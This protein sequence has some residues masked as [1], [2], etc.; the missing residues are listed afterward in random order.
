MSRTT[1]YIRLQETSV[2]EVIGN[3]D[4]HVD[5]IHFMNISS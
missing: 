5:D 3:V 1:Y 2:S 4:D